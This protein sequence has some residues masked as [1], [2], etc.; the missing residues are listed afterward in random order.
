VLEQYH[1]ELLNF[2][3][4]QKTDRD[5]AADLVQES[6]DRVLAV[7]HS[8]Q[9][10]GN[11]RALLYR[12]ARNQRALSWGVPGL[13]GW[14]TLM[15]MARWWPSRPWP[16]PAQWPATVGAARGLQVPAAARHT[17]QAHVTQVRLPQG[18]RMDNHWLLAGEVNEYV[19]GKESVHEH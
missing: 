16:R 6:Y 4:R 8:G 10:I 17:G 1:R 3:T 19:N 13:V 5:D 7:Q 9:V 2:R 18:L 11:D 14:R 15:V 12:S